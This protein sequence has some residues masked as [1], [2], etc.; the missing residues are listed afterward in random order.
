MSNAEYPHM[1]DRI[2]A[3]FQESSI[4]DYYYGVGD[5]KMPCKAEMLALLLME[6]VVF[7]FGDKITVHV[8]DNCQP[9]LT[10]KE[11]PILFEAYKNNGASG[12]VQWAKEK[13]G[14]VS[15]KEKVRGK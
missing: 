11:I 3:L 15:W 13:H 14:Y 1:L 8:A 12:V 7:C 5:Q 2:E 10:D 6:E 9:V 4:D